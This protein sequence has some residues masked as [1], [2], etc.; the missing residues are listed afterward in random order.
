MQTPLNPFKMGF[1]LMATL[2]DAPVQTVLI[3]MPVPYLG[4]RWK[5]WKT[6]VFPVR[7]TM[8]LGR[9]FRAAPGQDAHAFGEEIEAYFRAEAGGPGLLRRR[10]D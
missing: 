6:P 2:A 8:R 4:K 10:P 5:P 3:D 1:A 9:R 7:I